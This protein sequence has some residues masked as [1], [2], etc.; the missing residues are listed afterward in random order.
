ME[1]IDNLRLSS[2]IAAANAYDESKNIFHG[3]LPMIET[4]LLL[5]GDQGV[6]SF[7]ALQ[8]QI[9]DTYQVKIPK[10]T[11]RYLLEV[12]QNQGKIRFVHRKNIFIDKDKREEIQI[13]DETGRTI[14]DD[15]FLIFIEYLEKRGKAADLSEVRENICHWV[16]YNS[17]DLAQFIDIGT[18]PDTLVQ[19]DTLSDWPYYNDFIS[20]LI[21]S[22]K[23]G[24]EAFG[25]FVK[26]F[27]GAVQ[28]SLLN[29]SPEKL[30]QISDKSFALDHIILDTNFILRLMGL[31]PPMDNE[32][33][34]TTWESLRSNGAEFFVLLQTVQEASKSIKAFLQEIG[35]NA[36]KTHKVLSRFKLYCSGFLSAFQNGVSRTR[37]LECSNTETIIAFLQAEYNVQLI[38][39][40]DNPLISEEDINALVASKNMATYGAPQATHDLTLISYCRKRRNNRINSFSDVKWWVLTNDRKL[41][42]WNQ[43]NCGEYQECITEIQLSNL[44]WLLDRKDSGGGLVNTILAIASRFAIT[45]SEISAFSKQIASYQNRNAGIPTKMDK[46][47][48]IFAGGIL[49][50]DDIRMASEDEESFDNVIEE[51]ADVISKQQDEQ[52]EQLAVSKEKQEQLAKD[53]AE[54]DLKHKQEMDELRKQSSKERLEVKLKDLSR[55]IGE[56]DSAITDGKNMMSNTETLIKYLQSIE[57]N[58]GR[59]SV[60]IL[61]LPAVFV[62]ILFGLFALPPLIEFLKQHV[63]IMNGVFSFISGGFL[64]ALL[65]AIYYAVIGL[66]FGSLH[67]PKDLFDLLKCK[68]ML[69]KKKQFIIQHQYQWELIDKDPKIL[70]EEERRMIEEKV[71]IKDQLIAEQLEVNSKLTA[72]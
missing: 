26:I 27:D 15:F 8:K 31:Q 68:R 7:L 9:N 61:V 24:T 17:W 38:D 22:R 66:I 48:L 1:I 63:A 21:S 12:L 30:D 28:T 20:F 6:V 58:I 36:Q 44:L 3:F 51:R 10:T 25:S 43:K 41:T 54:L 5:S 55:K 72:L 56:T 71:G 69:R 37:F 39:D 46:L 70:L 11:L 35:P 65:V 49:T 14:T 50:E 23:N 59:S 19:S 57:K 13:H 62:L 16:Y 40:Y 52:K 33:A 18:M 67:K 32:A 53:L 45:P 2:Y 64:M 60:M 4:A 47:A 34:I 42:Y 29:F